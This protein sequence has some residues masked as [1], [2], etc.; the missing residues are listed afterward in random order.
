MEENQFEDDFL[1]DILPHPLRVE[2]GFF[3]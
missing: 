2:I 1:E 3:Q